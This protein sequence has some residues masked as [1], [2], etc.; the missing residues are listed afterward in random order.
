ME[1]QL[2][3]NKIY[4]GNERIRKIDSSG[5]ITTFAGTGIAG[6]SGDGL[7]ATAA[8]F[9]SPGNLRFDSLG[10]LY[11]VDIT[12]GRIR[13]INTAGIITTIAGN[14]SGVFSGDGGSP[15]LA[16]MGPQGIAIKGNGNILIADDPNV[17]IREI[18]YNVQAL[19]FNPETNFSISPNPCHNRIDVQVASSINENV[20]L[21]IT[22]LLG[23][24]IKELTT[25]TNQEISISLDAGPGVYLITATTANDH[26]TQ[27]IVNY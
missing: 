3:K 14:G 1:S 21:T 5:I 15:L 27:K 16:G 23:L 11:I 17:R 8:K 19:E 6:Y 26:F 4:I 20:T 25:F 7:P 22:D 24:K 13:K 9:N 2:T 18:K 10:N 12:Y